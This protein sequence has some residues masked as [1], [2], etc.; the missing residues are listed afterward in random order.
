[1]EKEKLF[2]EI[3]LTK[4]ET[5]AYMTLLKYD[6]TEANTIYKDSKVPFGKIYSVL[7]S[8]AEKG[9][10][11]IID[12]RPKK[13]RVIKPEIALKKYREKE[14]GWLTKKLNSLKESMADLLNEFSSVKM[15]KKRE[16]IFWT[17]EFNDKGLAKLNKILYYYPSKYVNLIPHMTNIENASTIFNEIV[18]SINKGVK[19]RILLTSDMF[20]SLKK[21]KGYLDLIKT[22]KIDV[23]IV[24]NIESYF[25]IIDGEI[26][27]F[28][29][30]SPI[31]RTELL[32]AMAIW[33]KNLADNLSE[34][35]EKIWARGEKP[36]L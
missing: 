8:L 30:T 24:K 1:M 26:V 22:K 16:E 25:A 6:V 33:N 15:Q 35:F 23:R 4:Y 5:K 20:N 14:E 13:Y 12:V 17:T 3:G 31:D 36:R 32:S 9:F 29:Q 27:F 19:F 2:S 18:S 11:E 34:E 10:V 21:N 28:L 7:D